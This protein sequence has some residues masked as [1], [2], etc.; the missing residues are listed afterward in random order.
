M[1]LLTLYSIVNGNINPKDK[2]QMTPVHCAAQ[3]NA[4]KHI[5]IMNEGKIKMN[6]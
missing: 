5:T 1:C 3:Y 6:Y 2:E 4:A